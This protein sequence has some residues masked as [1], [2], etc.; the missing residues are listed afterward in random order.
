LTGEHIG[1]VLSRENRSNQDADVVV[2][3]GRPHT[4]VRIGEGASAPAR[5]KISSTCG[6]FMRGSREIPCFPAKDGLADRAGRVDDHKP[7][8]HGHKKSDNPI[9]A[10]KSPTRQGILRQTASVFVGTPSEKKRLIRFNRLT[11]WDCRRFDRKSKPETFSF[12]GFNHYCRVNRNG[13]F[14]V[15]RITMKKRFTAKLH[16]V[17]AELRKRM[18]QTIHEQG[19][20]MASVV[21]GYFQYHVIPGNWATLGSFRSQRTWR[22]YKIPPTAEP[23]NLA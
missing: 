5:W 7:A 16:N 6:S 8:M 20:W 15:G 18:H 11:H 9:V 17:T 19:A 4:C 10:A 23:E 21:R 3:F 12:L 13:K 2:L 22:W 1:G 14:T